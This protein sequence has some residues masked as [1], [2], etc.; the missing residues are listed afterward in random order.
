MNTSE[1]WSQIVYESG[2]T[3]HKFSNGPFYVPHKQIKQIVSKIEAPNNKKEI[4]ILGYQATRESRPQYFIEN[5]LFLMPASN[6]E[7]VVIQGEGYIDIPEINSDAIPIKSKL[8]FEIESFN[9]GIS[10]MQYLDFA[11]VHGIT[12]Q[13][14]KDESIEL[15]VRGRKRTPHFNYFV[16]GVEVK[17]EGVQTEVDAGYEGKNSLTLIEAKSSKIKN[18]IIRQLYFPYRKWLMDIKKPIRNVF[19]QFEENSKTLSFWEYGFEDYLK[20][21]SIYL[22]KSEKYKLIQ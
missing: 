20:Y 11:F 5:N 16:N 8:D 3:H 6:K 7:W 4:R 14:L 21:D 2:L 9:V 1:I 13:F 19:F 18:E 22:I 12:Q 10:E 17:C 15:T